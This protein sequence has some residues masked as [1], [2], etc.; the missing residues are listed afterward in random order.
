M[1]VRKSCSVDV[2][3]QSDF[4]AKIFLSRSHVVKV[5]VVRKLRNEF[6]GIFRIALRERI[7]CSYYLFVAGFFGRLRTHNQHLFPRKLSS[8]PLAVSD[9]AIRGGFSL[10]AILWTEG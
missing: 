6:R 3:C 10:D 1:H 9:I 2:N 8:F 5:S 7:E 4:S